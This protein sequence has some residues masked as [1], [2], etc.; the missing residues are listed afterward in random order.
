MVCGSRPNTNSD[1]A[2]VQNAGNLEF[3][4]DTP[5]AETAE[6]PFNP[7]RDLEVPLTEL[8][9]EG[10]MLSSHMDA[11]YPPNSGVYMAKSKGQ[12]KRPVY[13]GQ[14]TLWE[15]LVQVDYR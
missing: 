2:D 14:Q 5:N 9:F 11:S 1:R 12:N 15:Y 8:E 13:D 10:H 3:Q 6:S 7:D 4:L